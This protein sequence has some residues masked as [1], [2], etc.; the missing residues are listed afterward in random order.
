MRRRGAAVTMV[1]PSS[2]SRTA[3]GAARRVV[4]V[5]GGQAAGAALKTLRQLGHAGPIVLVTDEAHAPYERPPLS[6]EYLCGAEQALRWVAPGTLANEQL[7]VN[8][9]AVA[10]DAARKTITCSDGSTIAYDLLLLAT[11]GSPRRLAVPGSELGLVHVLRNAS[12]AIALRRSIERCAR[13]QRRLLIVGGSW[14]GLEVAAIAREAGVE[15]TLVE[16][17]ERLCGRT[18]PAAAAHWLH[19]LHALRG[20]DLR[21]QTAVLRLEG[22]GE[23]GNA[24]LSD[25]TG[26]AIGAVVAG[27]GITPN[28]ALAQQMGLRIGSGIVVDAHGRTSAPDIY[29]AGDVT[30]QACAWHMAPV[31]IETWDNANRQGE[32]AARHIAG[33]ECAAPECAAPPWFWSDQYG[34]NL[35]VLGAPTCGDAVLTGTGGKDARLSVHLRGETVVGAVGINESREMRRLRKLWSAEGPLRRPDLARAGFELHQLQI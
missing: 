27:I 21:M 12:D 32:A 14:I 4:I 5:G 11:G 34:A 9:T 25:G 10:G 28:V 29:A 18:L 24:R 1:L 13:Q 23:V 3:A 31:R 30:E 26:L 35:Q 7:V 22:D 2:S 6:K 8:R 33:L 19:E 16:Q 20:V 15:V 17:G